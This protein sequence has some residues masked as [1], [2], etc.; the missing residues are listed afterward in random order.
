MPSGQTIILDKPASRISF[1]GA[2]TNG[3]GQSAAS[4]TYDDGTTGRDGPTSRSATG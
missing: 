4:V 3:G 1:V 2:G